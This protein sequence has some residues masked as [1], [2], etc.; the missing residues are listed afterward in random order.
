MDG[1]P[2][3]PEFVVKSPFFT[4]AAAA[5]LIGAS[6]A[7][8][9]SAP[10]SGIQAADMDKTVRPQDDLFQYA[11]GTWSDSEGPHYAQWEQSTHQQHQD[12][13]ARSAGEQQQYWSWRHDNP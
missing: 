10:I 13:S 8:A 5:L 12:Y 6:M 1:E 4:L 2:I 9:D 7:R 11:N 3:N